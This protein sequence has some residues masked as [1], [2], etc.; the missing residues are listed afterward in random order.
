MNDVPLIRV[1]EN[2]IPEGFTTDYIAGTDGA[3]LRV[4]YLPHPDRAKVRGTF[5][6][7]PGWAEFIE[8]YVEVATELSARGFDVMVCDPRGQ[9]YSQRLAEG[10]HRGLITDYSQ[11]RGDLD[12]VM[13]ALKARFAPPYFLLAHSMGGLITLDW[14]AGG[15]GDDL[16]GVILNAPFTRLYADPLKRSAA[17]AILRLGIMMGAQTRHLPGVPDHSMN[18][19]LNN[20]T[21]DRMRH[22]RFKR[23]Q[24]AAPEAIAGPPRFSWLNAAMAAQARVET[25]PAL[26]GRRQPTLLV[27]ACR[28]ET[29]DPAH[30]ELLAQRF[31]AIQL[32]C[33]QGA[34][35]E[36]LMER[37]EYRAEFWAAADAYIEARLADAAESANVPPPVSS[38]TPDSTRSTRISAS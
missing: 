14:L 2:P 29:V 16:C 1:P 17:R 19:E 31:P 12:Q 26:R 5:L 32:V 38:T 25:A 13:L 10:D 3:R 34:R 27:S 11:F 37:D 22:E 36:I 23:L 35:H 8:K 24:L 9:G 20:L 28:D 4:A 33:V 15:R 7:V 30:H 21:Q 18:F 6:V